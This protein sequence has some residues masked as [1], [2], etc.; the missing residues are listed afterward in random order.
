MGIRRPIVSEIAYRTWCIDE[1]GMDAMFLLEGN[2][3]ALLIDTGT[4]LFNVPELVREL[5][6]KP[7]IVALTHGHVDHAGGMD[8]FDEVFLH[9][10]DYGPARALTPER[11]AGYARRML[12]ISEGIYDISADDIIIPEEKAVMQ[13][14]K[15]GDCIRLGGRDVAVYETPGHTEGSLGFVDPAE[16]ILFSGDACNVNTLLALPG[17]KHSEKTTVSSLLRTAQKLE[18]LHPYYDRNYNGHVGYACFKSCLPMPDSIN[19]DCIELCTRLLDGR[20]QG[21]KI[22]DAFSGESLAATYNTCRIVYAPDQVR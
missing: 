5:T 12:D 7:L 4:G 15:E 1:F 16:R 8:Q 18:G 13:P 3:R 21:E 20:I 10:D 9:P 19:R 11:R 2:D 14:L 22:E 6:A 17:Q